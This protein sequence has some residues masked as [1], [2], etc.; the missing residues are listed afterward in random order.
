MD[1]QMLGMLRE[2]QKQP[3]G[4]TLAQLREERGMSQGELAKAVGMSRPY[5]TQIEN[6]T[7]TPSTET[8]YKL[9]AALGMEPS[10][11]SL[12]TGDLTADDLMRMKEIAETLELIKSR[13]SDTEWERVESLFGDAPGLLAF[14]DRVAVSMHPHEPSPI[15][16][17]PGWN[18]LNRHNRR[19]IRELIDQLASSQP[20]W[21][22]DHDAD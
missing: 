4:R 2:I 1:E 14:T 10:S 12:M 7:R 13:L 20:H 9:G 19:L 11:V 3:F 8:A 21:E 17:I 6:G 22:D 15:E 18:A 16:P 5:V